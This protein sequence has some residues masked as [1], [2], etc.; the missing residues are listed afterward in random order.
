MQPRAAT[1]RHFVRRWGDLEDPAL[2]LHGQGNDGMAGDC[3]VWGTVGCGMVLLAVLGM[4]QVEAEVEVEVGYRAPCRRWR[5]VIGG[6]SEPGDGL[7][8][9][10]LTRC[11]QMHTP[12]PGWVCRLQH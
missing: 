2:H 8:S 1:G 12:S 9:V 10:P 11:I 3:G 5:T 7:L 6:T 4:A